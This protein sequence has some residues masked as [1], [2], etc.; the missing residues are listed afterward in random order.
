MRGDPRSSHVLRRERLHIRWVVS[1]EGL[2]DGRT[3]VMQ[4]ENATT[5]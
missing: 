2:S 1:V 3:G 5:E 4:K